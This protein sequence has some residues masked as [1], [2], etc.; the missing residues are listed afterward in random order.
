MKTSNSEKFIPSSIN[1]LKSLFILFGTTSTALAISGLIAI[2]LGIIFLLVIPGL[3]D[4]GT[5]IGIIGIIS[6]IASIT[7][8]YRKIR[9]SILSK[10]R[11]N[12]EH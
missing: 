3:R 2:A 7:L 1:K 12:M 10:T 4:I 5:I 11:E 8:S 6:I 9:T